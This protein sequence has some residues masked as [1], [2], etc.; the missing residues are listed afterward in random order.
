MSPRRSLTAGE[1]DRPVPLLPDHLVD[2]HPHRLDRGRPDSASVLAA[3][4][5]AVAAGRTNYVDPTTGWTVLT[6]QFLW[7]RGTCCDTGCRHCPYYG[8]RRP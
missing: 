6:A 4:R 8:D 2:P 3:H 1:A 7:E 5:R